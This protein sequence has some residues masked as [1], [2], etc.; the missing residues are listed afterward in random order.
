MPTLEE[1]LTTS[2]KTVK[3]LTLMVLVVYLATAT[4]ILAQSMLST[5][6]GAVAMKLTHSSQLKCAAPAV[7]EDLSMKEKAKQVVMARPVVMGKLEEMARLAVMERRVVMA[8]PAEMPHLIARK[9]VLPAQMLLS[10]VTSL[11]G[12]AAGSASFQPTPQSSY[13]MS[14]KRK[15]SI[16][17]QSAIHAKTTT[18]TASKDAGTALTQSSPL[19]NEP[20]QIQWLECHSECVSSR[21]RINCV[22]KCHIIVFSKC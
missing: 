11:A 5:Q 18:S 20:S 15:A 9:P 10:L 8:R 22:T 19:W 6:I 4:A 16:V 21:D 2:T 14:P 1:A 7:E 3:T 13:L 17:R 12:K